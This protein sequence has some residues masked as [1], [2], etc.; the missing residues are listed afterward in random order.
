MHEVIHGEKGEKKKRK[1]IVPISFS[2]PL[3]M[4]KT[5]HLEMEALGARRVR[6]S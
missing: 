1:K 5:V 4:K 2:I 3:V 6:K